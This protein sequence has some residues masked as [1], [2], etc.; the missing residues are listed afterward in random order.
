M[1]NYTRRYAGIRWSL[2]HGGLTGTDRFAVTEL[3]R[4]VQRFLPYVLPI[5]PAMAPEEALNEH[6]IL[7]GTVG[8]NPLLA[9]LTARGLLDLV[10]AGQGFGLACL[11]SPWHEGCRVLA[12]VGQDAAGTLHGVEEF[13]AHVL[14]APGLMPDNPTPER[15]RRAFDG[16]ADFARCAAPA[17]RNR[18]IW[19]WGYVIYDYRR[20]IDNMARLKFNMLTVWNDVP[21]V[22]SAELIDYAHRRG[23]RILFGFPWGWGFPDADL[24][25]AADRAMIREFVLR[26]FAEHYAGLDLDGIYFQTLTEHR[27]VHKAGRSTAS[28]ACELVNAIAGDLYAA[29]PDLAIQFGLHASSIQDRYVDLLELD[30]RVVIVWE[31]AGTIPFSYE[32]VADQK[33]NKAGFNTTF[34]ET[35][36]YARRLATFRKGTEFALVPKGWMHLRWPEDFEHH[37][38]FILGE[39]DPGWIRRRLAER[40]PLWDRREALWLGN[41]HYAQRFYREMLAACPAGLTVTGLVED[42]L[43]EARIQPSVALFAETLWAPDRPESDLRVRA[44]SPYYTSW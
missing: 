1:P 18:G 29:R 9:D 40:Q 28:L 17:V 4:V 6:L 11:D 16:L 27:E 15:L 5:R 30:P 32:V 26:E 2:V 21:P 43:F 19:T 36:E 25:N 10:V 41:F 7:V 37:G 35:L 20:F 3:Q 33:G 42:G 12:V 24:A 34:E 8:N 14:D 31:D 38:P 44:A 13:C 39:R 23:V 22:N